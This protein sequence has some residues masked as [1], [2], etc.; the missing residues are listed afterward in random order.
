MRRVG[1]GT[2]VGPAGKLPNGGWLGGGGCTRCVLLKFPVIKEVIMSFTTHRLSIII[3]SS[4][5]LD[6]VLVLVYAEGIVTVDV[7]VVAVQS[8][9]R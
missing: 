8:V 3:M 7:T 5:I 1:K 6:L 9:Q 2:G 4:T